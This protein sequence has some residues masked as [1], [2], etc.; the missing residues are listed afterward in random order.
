MTVVA[1]I[2]VGSNLNNPYQQ[3]KSAIGK[4]KIA[5]NIY[6]ET[7]SGWYLSDPVGPKNQ[8]R[9]VNGVIKISTRL[10][11]NQLLKKLHEIED[12]HGRIRNVRWGPRTLDLDILLYGSRM[13]N[14]KKLT[15]P[16]PEMKIRNFVLTPL[17]DIEPDLV[18]PDGSILSSLL[19]NNQLK[20]V[21]PI[22]PG[23]VIEKIG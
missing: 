3:V 4:L 7:I 9:Y 22:L 11:P 23:D 8:S 15:I 19:E 17:A 2:S 21:V 13:M 6:I 1:Y 16:H 14:T 18:L 12:A 10:S 20:E 5:D